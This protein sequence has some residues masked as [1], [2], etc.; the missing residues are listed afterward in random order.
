MGRR[1]PACCRIGRCG[2]EPLVLGHTHRLCKLPGYD[3]RPDRPGQRSRP[4]PP[5]GAL[6]GGLR[7]SGAL[8]RGADERHGAPHHG[9]RAGRT[10]TGR[11][12]RAY[13][14]HDHGNQSGERN[15]LGRLGDRGHSQGV[16]QR[17]RPEELPQP[18]RHPSPHGRRQAVRHGRARAARGNSSTTPT[19]R[20]PRRK[21]RISTAWRPTRP[22]CRGTGC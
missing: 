15:R 20:I 21:S 5:R 10:P 7:P 2:V 17:R 9:R 12:P 6:P 14:H 22:F 11:R 3:P 16:S 1:N 4:H 19:P 18:A 13:S 8:R